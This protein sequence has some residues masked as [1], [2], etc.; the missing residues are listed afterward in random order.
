MVNR[1]SCAYYFYPLPAGAEY[2][3][4]TKHVAWGK[5]ST[6]QEELYSKPHTH[7]NLFASSHVPVT[8]F[9]VCNELPDFLVWDIQKTL[10]SWMVSPS[11]AV[12]RSFLWIPLAVAQYFFFFFFFFNICIVNLPGFTFSAAQATAITNS[13]LNSKQMCWAASTSVGSLAS[14]F[15]S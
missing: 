3:D 15:F 7:M 1:C 13:W 2:C 14:K 11:E 9:I 6:G 4:Y 8:L 10:F 5:Y 12:E